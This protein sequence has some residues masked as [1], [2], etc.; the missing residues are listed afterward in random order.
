M[1]LLVT[2]IR[3]VKLVALIL[4]IGGIIPSYS[5][6]IKKGLVYITI[7]APSSRQ[8]SSYTEYIRSNVR[9]SYNVRS[10]SDTEYK[11]TIT[12]LTRLTPY[13]ICRRVSGLIYC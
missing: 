8:P 10:V 3:Q 12:R 13:L 6:Y 1:P 9:I 11:R 7:V 2:S 5:R 4:S